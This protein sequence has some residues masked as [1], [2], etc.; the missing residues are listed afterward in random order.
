M[1]M[2]CGSLDAVCV[3]GSRPC[4]GVP[5]VTAGGLKLS[6]LLESRSSCFAHFTTSI[7]FEFVFPPVSAPGWSQRHC[8]LRLWLGGRVKNERTENKSH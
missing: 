5:T 4:F 1:R 2:L 3:S 8:M 6:S 7:V